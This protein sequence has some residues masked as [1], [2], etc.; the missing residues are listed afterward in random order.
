MAN[1]YY[2]QPLLAAIR[3]S[4]HTSAGET[5]LIVTASQ[6]GYAAGLVFLL[7]LGD[8]LERRR[9]V[10]VMSLVT[11]AGLVGAAFSPVLPAL[12]GAAAIVGANSVVAQVL[13]AFSASLAGDSER[14][15]VVGTVMSGLLLGILLARTAAGYI[16]EA[17]SWRVVFVVA[18]VLMA[19][20]AA[21]LRNQLPA[22]REPERLSY[23]AVLASVVALMR[24]ERV[25]RRRSLY[26]S[27]SFAA[28]SVL[29]TSLAFLLSSTPYHYATGTIGLFGLA[30]V[31]GAAMAQ[32][33]GRLADRGHQ[34]AVTVFTCF[35]MLVAFAIMGLGRDLVGVLVAGIVVLDL[36][37]QG[38]HIT[39]QSEIYRLAPNARSRVNSAYM[40]SYFIGGTLGS[41]GSALCYAAGGWGAVCALG[42]GLGAVAAALSL[43]EVRYSREGSSKAA[44]SGAP[45]QPPA[46]AGTTETV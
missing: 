42:A 39:N 32:V 18:A 37:C 2:A 4:F 21:V 12:F 9:L 36:G 6:I 7:P 13:V 33:S 16:A 40:T 20:L 35:A 38:L 15:R 25:L 44:V 19:L 5:G 31:A 34:A 26:G 1:G 17:S 10:V 3:H 24:A 46:T 22:H 27:L 8:L 43:T 11:A 28:F 41:V 45:A 30:G 23:P 14:G 29:W